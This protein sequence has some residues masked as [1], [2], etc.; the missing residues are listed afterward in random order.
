VPSSRVPS[1]TSATSSSASSARTERSID[2]HIERVSLLR[3]SSQLHTLPLL[4]FACTI[5]P[6]CS[7]PAHS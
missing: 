7:M 5:S 6:T 1:T 4:S 2:A 3:I